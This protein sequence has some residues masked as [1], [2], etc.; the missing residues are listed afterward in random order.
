[1]KLTKKALAVA[2]GSAMLMASVTAQAGIMEALFQSGTNI[3][4]DDSAEYV[5]R[6]NPNAVAG[7]NGALVDGYDTVQGNVAED[8]I[9][10]GII[11]FPELTRPGNTNIVLATPDVEIGGVFLGVFGPLTNQGTANAVGSTINPDPYAD[12]DIAFSAGTAQ[13]WNDLLGVS[14]SGLETEFGAAAGDFDDIFAVLIEDE[15][16]N[17]NVFT[18]PDFTTLK[19]NILDG[20]NR[21]VLGFDGTAATFVQATDIALS[22]LE[23]SP[24][25]NPQRLPGTTELGDF[26]YN[27]AV[28]GE[29]LSGELN[30]NFVGSGT[31]LVSALAGAPVQDDTQVTFTYVPIPGPL[32]L[33][34]LGLMGFALRKKLA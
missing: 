17:L 33:M 6:E 21:I 31:N 20:D 24:V 16:N 11:D 2:C 34:G 5:F 28:L 10:V 25:L 26:G 1:M 18:D 27:L 32:A 9:F 22:T 15:D 4:E 19:A 30:G 14:L 8:D 12:V 13:M 29:N 23:F 7:V 3:L